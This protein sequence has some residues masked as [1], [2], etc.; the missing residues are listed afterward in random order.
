MGEQAT[1]RHADV[2]RDFSERDAIDSVETGRAQR[3][4]DD[5]RAGIGAFGHGPNST[6]DRS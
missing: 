4:L 1:L 5:P 6:T 2:G 3:R